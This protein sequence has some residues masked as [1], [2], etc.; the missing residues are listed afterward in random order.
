M[1]FIKYLFSNHVLNTASLGWFIAQF[2]KGLIASVRARRLLVDRFFG[3]G[4][5]PSSHG[6]FVAALTT[7]VLFTDGFASSSFAIAA[8]LAFIVL[9]DASG[10]RYAV[11]Q[12]AKILNTFNRVY[13]EV[14][15]EDKLF[16]KDL[17]ELIGHT[18]M[19]VT[20]GCILGVLIAICYYMI[21][22]RVRG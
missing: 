11:G 3:A 5:M 15:E 20:V 13:E 8:V 2:L 10:V 9:Y 22:W 18:K 21:L 1:D 4:G 16:E 6:A 7:A 14:Y 19:E 12:Q 17:K